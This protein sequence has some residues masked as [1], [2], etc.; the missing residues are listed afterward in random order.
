MKERN[1][2]AWIREHVTDKSLASIADGIGMKRPTFWRKYRD[3][4]FDAGDVIALARVLHVNPIDALVENGWLE[5]Y[6]CRTDSATALSSVAL[7]H[8]VTRRLTEKPV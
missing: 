6:E 2:P 4:A 5:T 3:D 1:T 7:A 8:E